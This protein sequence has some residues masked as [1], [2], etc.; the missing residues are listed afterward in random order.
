MMLR[1]KKVGNQK[2]KKKKKVQ[3]VK[4]QIK[5]KLSAI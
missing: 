1:P 2:K 4:E 5:T 3:T